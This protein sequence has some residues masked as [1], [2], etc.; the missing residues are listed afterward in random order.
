MLEEPASIARIAKA[1]NL[2]LR[3]Y[4]FY[5]PELLR[6]HAIT[7]R[8]YFQLAPP[9]AGRVAQFMSRSRSRADHII[10][11]HIRQGDYATYRGGEHFFSLAQYA[12]LMRQ[13]R[14]LLAPSTV[15]FVVCSDALIADDAFEGLS[16]E[17]GP[18]AA[19]EDLYA[20]AGCDYVLGPCSTFNRWSAFVGNV[21]RYEIRDAG[22]RIT[23][24]DF[25]PPLDL[26]VP[27]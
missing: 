23:L 6:K 4:Y 22:R 15:H 14:Q 2:V 16:W 1:S 20:L 12:A 5:A 25:A 21:P 10:G 24:A 9:Y 26:T 8:R 18:G 17:V 3:G 13:V 11:V 27:D 7:I 19:V